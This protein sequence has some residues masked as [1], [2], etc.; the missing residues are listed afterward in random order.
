MKMK[1]TV[2]IV[3]LA[4]ALSVTLSAQTLTE[5][6]QKGIFAEETLGNLTEAAKVYRQIIAAPAVPRAIAQEA[7]R[8]LARLLARQRAATSLAKVAGPPPGQYVFPDQQPPRGTVEQNR[9][10]HLSSGITF[11]L[12]AGWTAS[13]TSGSSDGGDMVILTEQATRRSI[14]VWMI[15]EE[16]PAALVAARV[17]GAPAEK[18]RQRHNGYGIPGMLEP[19]TYD[20]PQRSVHPTVI[21]GQ[22]AVVA[23]GEYRGLPIGDRFFGNSVAWAPK[24]AWEAMNELMTWIYTPHSRVFFFARIRVDDLPSLRPY[25]DQ[26]VHSAIIP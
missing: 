18:I 19:E 22:K 20:I 8:R 17:A 5:H 10:R 4:A 2:R 23:V 7:E 26:I 3:V 15:K 13:E 16:T 1:W 24:P 6:L 25:F 21:N 11:D 12:P 9:Y 14:S